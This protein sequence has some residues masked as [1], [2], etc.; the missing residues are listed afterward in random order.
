MKILRYDYVLRIHFSEPVRNHCFTLKC[1]PRSDRRQQIMEQS[2]QISPRD[3]LCD[4]EDSFGNS[5]VFG[6]VKDF[7]DCFEVRVHGTART[8]LH[9]R[10]DAAPLYRLGMFHGQTEYTQPDERLRAFHSQ[11]H[12]QGLGGNYERSLWLMERLRENFTYVSGVTDVTTTAA[13]A[14]GLGQG[15]CQ[16][17]AHIFLSLCRMSGIPCRYVVGMLIGEGASHAWVEVFDDGFWY[18]VDPTNGIPVLED[19]V[20]ISHGRDFKDCKINQGVFSGCAIQTQEVSVIVKEAGDWDD[21]VS[22]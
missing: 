15:V 2:I 3:S 17:Y 11:L 12:Y 7:H 19:H 6:K 14:F 5:Y 16:D 21:N 9:R 13:Q 22:G 10:I 4:N 18:G 1:I 20:K 8:G